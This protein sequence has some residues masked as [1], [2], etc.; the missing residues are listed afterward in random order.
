MT[1]YN[2]IVIVPTVLFFIILLCGSAFALDLSNV[3]FKRGNLPQ[4]WQMTNDYRAPKSEL[5]TFAKKFSIDSLEGLSNQVFIVDGKVR[6]QVNYVQCKD[7][8]EAEK[9]ARHFQKMVGHMNKILLRENI[10]IEII[11]RP[12]S[13]Q[14]KNQVASLLAPAREIK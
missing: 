5:P 3:V 4:G 14:L 1:R 2:R 13:V 8:A 10:V 9:V 12:E 7:A 11:T 6:L